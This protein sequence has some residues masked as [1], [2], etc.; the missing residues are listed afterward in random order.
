ML[1]HCANFPSQ[2]PGL[3]LERRTLLSARGDRFGRRLSNRSMSFFVHA[4][5]SYAPPRRKPCSDTM[6]NH[7]TQFPFQ[8]WGLGLEGRSLLLARLDRPGQRRGTNLD[9][10]FLVHTGTSDTQ[11]PVVPEDIDVTDKDMESEENLWDLYE[12]WQRC[13]RKEPLDSNENQRRF[14]GFMDSARFIHEF[15]KRK[16]TTFTVGLSPFSDL[17]DD[18][19]CDKYCGARVW[20][21]S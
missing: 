11:S 7:R 16:D 6:L 14:K 8:I 18:E 1:N 4:G 12:R 21:D 19:F 17:T 5:L 9:T 2:Y 3:R 20:S 10:S 15:S 13:Y